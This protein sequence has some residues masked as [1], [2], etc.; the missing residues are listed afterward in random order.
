MRSDDDFRC[1][2][3]PQKLPAVAQM[4]FAHL[5]YQ[6]RGYPSRWMSLMS[7]QEPGNR[8]PRIE[9]CAAR[10]QVASP[11]LSE[12]R[13]VCVNALVR[14]CA[15]GDQQWPSLLRQWREAFRHCPTTTYRPLR[16]RRPPGWII[17]GW[18]VA[19]S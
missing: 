2:V 5:R 15:G 18:R 17:Y 7:V 10:R 1:E 11:P 16:L 3:F 9:R 8:V 13:A 14:I 6:D 4:L 19:R 12:V